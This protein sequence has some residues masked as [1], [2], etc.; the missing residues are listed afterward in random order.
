M[1]KKPKYYK[2]ENEKMKTITVTL[3]RSINNGFEHFSIIRKYGYKTDFMTFCT[4]DCHE[5]GYY[6]C[7]VNDNGFFDSIEKPFPTLDDFVKAVFSV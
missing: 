7:G 1:V 5:N 2:G 3:E 6:A 4:G